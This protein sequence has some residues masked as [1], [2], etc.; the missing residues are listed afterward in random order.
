[1]EYVSQIAVLH[2][3]AVLLRTRWAAFTARRISGGSSRAIAP[4]RSNTTSCMTGMH[5]P[6]P[7]ILPMAQERCTEQNETLEGFKLNLRL[8]HIVHWAAFL[9]LEIL[10][11]SVWGTPTFMRAQVSG[12]NGLPGHLLPPQLAALLPDTPHA[13][14]AP[15]AA[16]PPSKPLSRKETYELYYA[17][18]TFF[19]AFG[20]VMLCFGVGLGGQESQF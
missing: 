10:L 11:P 19:C 4:S 8:S 12:R 7:S 18:C 6:L 2:Q 14:A 9:P 17:Q 1:M 20:A 5:L 16:G 3:C 15:M 13:G